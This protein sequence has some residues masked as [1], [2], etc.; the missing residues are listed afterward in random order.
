MRTRLPLD[1]ALSHFLDERAAREAAAAGDPPRDDLERAAAIRAA[2]LR[3][4]TERG[5]IAGIPRDVRARDVP[6]TPALP[7]RV[8]TPPGTPN[9]LVVHLHGGAWVTGSLA[10]HDPFCRLLSAGAGVAVLAVDY[11]LAPEHPFPAALE[12]TAAAYA[13]A[14]REAR[15]LGCDPERLV[16][17]GDSAGANLAT[18]LALQLASESTSHGMAAQVLL[19][20]VTDHFSGQHASYREPAHGFGPELMDWAWRVYARDVAPTDPRLSPLRWPRIPALPPTLVATAEYDIL[21]DEALAYADRLRAAGVAVTHHHAPDMHH[22][23][24]VSAATVARFPQCA[25]ALAVLT[26]WLKRTLAA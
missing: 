6:L 2:T 7:G 20:P 14:R 15:A 24:C 12:D 23:F 13:W 9:A 17:S 22:N 18:V 8:Y 26:D 3:G 19:Y 4:L 5:D 25:A 11:R 1:P 16:L 10:S 21:R